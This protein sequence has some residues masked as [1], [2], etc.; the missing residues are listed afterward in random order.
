MTITYAGKDYSHLANDLPR[1]EGLLHIMR[2][3]LSRIAPTHSLYVGAAAEI[4][5]VEARLAEMEAR[6]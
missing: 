5:A 6:R 2:R 3:G 1:L 4:A